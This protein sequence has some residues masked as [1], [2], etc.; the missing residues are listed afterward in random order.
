MPD[1]IDFASKLRAQAAE[2]EANANG[3]MATAKIMLTQADEERAIADALDPP[4]VVDPPPI[5]APAPPVAPPIVAPSPFPP[6]TSLRTMFETM[7]GFHVGLRSMPESY[8]SGLTQTDL[9]PGDPGLLTKDEG[10]TGARGEIGM[11]AEWNV[12]AIGTGDP[13]AEKYTDIVSKVAASMPIHRLDRSTGQPV[14]FLDRPH[15]S[16]NS[17]STNDTDLT[18]DPASANGFAIDLQHEPHFLFAAMLR[19]IKDGDSAAQS[20]ILYEMKCYCAFNYL[21][22]PDSLRGFERGIF[23]TAGS[24]N[25]LRG[26]GWA[27]LPLGQTLPFMDRHDPMF[28]SLVNSLEC[29]AAWQAGTFI[30][31]TPVVVDDA[32]G[33]P[34]YNLPE[35]RF[36]ND[37]TIFGVSN[38]Y[39]RNDGI[40]RIG[41]F[42]HNF[43][44]QAW[45]FI[46][47]LAKRGYLPVSDAAIENMRLIA[48]AGAKFTVRMFGDGKEGRPDYR[49]AG[50]YDVAVGTVGTDG[51]LVPFAT[52]QELA[53]H[54]DRM[55][56]AVHPDE[57]P[58][59]L[60]Y[61]D[62]TADQ[63]TIGD[64]YYA[65][66]IPVLAG[67][68]RDDVP[69]A[70]DAW[71][72]LVGTSTYQQS[73]ATI[74]PAFAYAPDGVWFDDQDP[75]PPVV[76]PPV[77][78]DPSA[79]TTVWPV[80]DGSSFTLA[81][82][83]TMQYGKTL[84]EPETGFDGHVWPAGAYLVAK[85]LTAGT[86]PVS[87]A[88]FGGV[89]PIYG[90]VKGAS[91]LTPG[92]GPISVTPTN[93][94]PAPVVDPLPP[95][96]GPTTVYGSSSKTTEEVDGALAMP[97]P[98]TPVDPKTW[99]PAEGQ[100]TV[101]PM[102][103]TIRQALPD[104][105]QQYASE[106]T[107]EWPGAVWLPILNAICQGNSGH[108]PGGYN[109]QAFVYAFLATLTYEAR[110]YT[111]T[112]HNE[113]EWTGAPDQF[114]PDEGPEDEA[115]VFHNYNGD[116]FRPGDIG[117]GPEAVVLADFWTAVAP[118]KNPIVLMNP[119]L[120]H[121]GQWQL[122]DD[123]NAVPIGNYAVAEVSRKLKGIFLADGEAGAQWHLTFIGFDGKVDASTYPQVC[124]QWAAPTMTIDEDRDLVIGINFSVDPY[125]DNAKT[126]TLSFF[127][128]DDPSKVGAIPVT[129]S[130][131]KI[132]G[133]AGT[134]EPNRLGFRWLRKKGLVGYKQYDDGTAGYVRIRLIGGDWPTDAVLEPVPMSILSTNGNPFT[135]TLPSL[136]NHA[137]GS[138]IALNNPFP[139]AMPGQALMFLNTGPDT[140]P[141]IANLPTIE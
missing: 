33:G 99:V 53:A 103:N 94:D 66:A 113:P 119:R 35:G 43:F 8:L 77:P 11:M 102:K 68:V 105:L 18:D 40:F 139:D 128:Q 109:L 95:T 47:G 125:H 138:N 140:P 101:A 15:A 69:G 31:G 108:H 97:I 63:G 132:L 71:G 57:Q 91:P 127:K 100:V 89:D 25:D 29:N 86:Y 129:I 67:A 5:V 38:T 124:G 104:Y 87:T 85:T 52:D 117:C 110:N 114:G 116:T 79:P 76:N 111:R 56:E 3:L 14:V 83:T 19:A 141:L 84:T 20:R 70:Q 90:I 136:Q 27:V 92:P 55:I 106:I 131:P 88:T 17:S 126:F 60:R 54:N 115:E 48:S 37:L 61:H 51:F 98:G 73:K 32:W 23:N 72:R 133:A 24:V 10:A 123:A 44:V 64:G 96:A 49:W 82:E 58:P 46:Y 21:D 107:V 42:Q 45:Q 137:F 118:E 134:V 2:T 16:I 1:T 75:T 121:G 78:V 26:S 81:A 30:P 41:F 80:L 122:L 28:S 7:T 36:K 130:D 13:R 12:V 62:G 59:F 135:T 6:G 74:S 93:P 50:M 4:P 9:V 39:D 120:Q 34:Y 65:N 112:L 22:M